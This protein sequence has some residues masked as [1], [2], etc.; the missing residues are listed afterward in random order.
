MK[1][2]NFKTMDGNETAAYVSYAFTEAAG[3]YPITPSSP[4]AEHID[5]WSSEGRKNLFGQPVKVIEMQSEAGAAGTMHGLLQSG[6][7]ASTYTASQGLLLMIPNMYKMAGELLPGV[8]HVAARSIA[9]HALSIF[10]DHQDIYAT[11]PTGFAILASG[12][13]QE[14]MDLAGIAHLSAIKGRVSFLHFFDGFRTSHEV[15]KIEVIDYKVFDKLLDKEKVKEFR[16]R[17]LNPNNPVIRGTNQNDDIYFQAREAQNK[18]YLEIPD[19]VNEYMEKLEKEIG[20]KYRPFVYYGDPNATDIIVAM[21]SVTETIKETV[22]YINKQGGRVGA[23]I[24]H[25]YRP[26]SKKYFL[27]VL[28]K[29][30]ERIAVLDRTK[31]PG[32][33][34]EPLYL[35]V[36]SV[37]AGEKKKPY[38]IGGRYG[39]SSKDTNPT[40]IKAVYDFLNSEESFHGFTI[41]I[42]D[43][44]TNLSIKPKEKIN[45]NDGT[46]TE[47][48]CYGYGSDGTVG[49]SENTIKILGDKTDLYAQ[50][51]FVYDS[52]KSGG[53]TRAHLRFGKKPIRAPY[54]ITNPDFISCSRDAYLVNYDILEGIKEGGTFLLN[55]VRDE[56]ELI[57]FIPNKMKKIMA[58]KNI[59][60]YIINAVELAEKIG[61]KGKI[62]T[63]MQSAFFKLNPN[64]LDYELAK[65]YMKEYAKASYGKKGSNVVELNYQAIDVAEKELKEIKVDPNWKN[66]KVEE[67]EN[68]RPPHIRDFEDPIEE[69]KG[70]SLSVSVF[71]ERV[72]GTFLGGTTKYLKRG[73]TNYV[74]KWIPENCIQC[75]RCSFVCPHAVIRP[76]ILDEEEQK[77][78]P[79]DMITLG[80]IGDR[81][82]KYKYRIQVSPL[83][84]TGCTLCVSTC[85]GKGGK[86]ALEM[87]T[88]EEA[89]D[90]KEA[91]YADY[92]FNHVTYKTHTM[93]LTTVKGSQFAEPLFE[94]NS[95][96]AGCGETPYI[97]LIT[98]LF[99]ERM[100][101]ANA[102][103][104]SSIYGGSVPGLPYTKSKA[105]KGPA[106]ANSLFEDNAEFG[107]GIALGNIVMKNKIYNL[108]Y[109]NINEFKGKIKEKLKEFLE[110]FE[111]D[112]K[113]EELS[114]EIVPLLEESNNPIA[115]E[116]V[117]LKDYLEKRSIWIV[118]GDGWAYDI[119]FG[120]LDHIFANRENVNILVLDTEVYSNTGGQSSKASQIGSIAKFT[121]SG[122]K[123]NKKDLAAIAMSYGHVY[124]AQVSM[125]ADYNQLIQAIKEA[126]EYDGPSLIIA[127]SP[128][129]AHGITGG[130]TNSQEQEKLASLCGYW[131]LF[132]FN[133][134][135]ENK[136]ILDQDEPNWDLYHE[137]LNNEKRYAM[138]YA[139]NKEKAAYLLEENKKAAI[140]RWNY[141]KKLAELYEKEN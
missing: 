87:I 120:G 86:K 56:K 21:G 83:D 47:C 123:T 75:N 8:I 85:P 96:C 97:K 54:L 40:H 114:K 74:P 36:V 49:A 69:L 63:I 119:G 67:K 24:V 28:P 15:Q 33:T 141:Y 137:F 57:N 10:G 99:G 128:C 48:L 37:F 45:V 9:T 77:N 117:E 81:E 93:P 26:F 60:F 70:N 112:K 19:I 79:D 122:K 95:A 125:G 135:K 34:G 89:I 138:L 139:V 6:V 23:I 71:L 42:D 131:P 13:V 107:Y 73:V 53:V 132:R 62:N 94:F 140:G 106:W 20:R 98:Q 17:A 103:G 41:G 51:Y 110:N 88:L 25:L 84:C 108:I 80:L 35:D 66:L 22:D 12:S 7:L 118:G 104:C 58:E 50:A 72:D 116:I 3:I 90:E 68:N 109:D 32:A 126:E 61:L 5:I 59:K 92:M 102:T 11:R 2:R 113:R 30:V 44:V 115:K 111:E 127:Y 39:L 101:I 76:F 16:S 105:G 43:D 124:V 38:I 1:Q 133:P 52:K 18:Y 91:E 134:T 65:K 29:T 136:L 82:G 129:I 55:T 27:E 130:M 100:I 31:E 121:A 14:V 4:M 78:A 46:V 64:L